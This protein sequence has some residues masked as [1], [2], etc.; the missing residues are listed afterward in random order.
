MLPTGSAPNA[1]PHCPRLTT[2]A[3]VLT[4]GKVTYSY[5]IGLLDPEKVR[6]MSGVS[7]YAP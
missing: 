6:F 4:P 3:P 7:S 5:A 2:T 1:L